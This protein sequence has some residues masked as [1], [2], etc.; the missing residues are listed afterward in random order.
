MENLIDILKTKRYI[1]KSKKNH[2]M[3]ARIG[4]DQ[5]ISTVFLARTDIRFTWKFFAHAEI[6]ED[7]KNGFGYLMEV[8]TPHMRQVLFCYHIENA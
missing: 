8:L 7:T 4:R 5:I 6:W 2:S 3:Y 1:L